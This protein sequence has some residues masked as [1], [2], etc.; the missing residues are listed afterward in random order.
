[1]LAIA[2]QK[3]GVLARYGLTRVEADRAAWTVDAD[4]HKLEGAA[5]VNTVLA[6][7]GGG[8]K[9]AAALYGVKPVAAVEEAAYRWL[10]P[11]R[12]VL[13]RFGVTPECEEPDADCA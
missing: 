10:A 3:R 8:W 9:I 5:A 11:R 13:H 12:S 4:G 2:N 1:V 7:L 6:A